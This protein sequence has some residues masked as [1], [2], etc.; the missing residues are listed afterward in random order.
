MS[1][2][3]FPGAAPSPKPSV[4][5]GWFA[6]RPIVCI[7]SRNSAIQFNAGRVYGRVRKALYTTI[8]ALFADASVSS[9]LNLGLAAKGERTV[10]SLSVD[11]SYVGGSSGYRWNGDAEGWVYSRPYGGNKQG[12]LPDLTH[13]KTRMK[14]EQARRH[15]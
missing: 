10:L 4:G 14:T 8:H 1:L 7:S 11:V 9:C 2:L 3:R 5:E 15:R 6:V 13:P 12:Q